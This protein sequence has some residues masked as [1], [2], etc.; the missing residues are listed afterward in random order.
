V[1]RNTRQRTY[2]QDERL[3]LICDAQIIG[4]RGKLGS[5]TRARTD[6]QSIG[7]IKMDHQ[8]TRNTRKKIFFEKKANVEQKIKFG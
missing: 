5:V 3:V 2:F 7:G 1:A 8:K 4:P 6:F